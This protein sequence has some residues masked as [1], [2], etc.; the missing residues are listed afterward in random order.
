M[1]IQNFTDY[2]KTA[3]KVP[4]LTTEAVRAR[5]VHNCLNDGGARVKALSD[6]KN[7]TAED[8]EDLYRMSFGDGKFLENEH[9]NRSNVAEAV[10]YSLETLLFAY[11][12]MLDKGAA[13]YT[14][15]GSNRSY[16]GL[17]ITSRSES[18]RRAA[19]LAG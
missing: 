14:S 18:S 12:A 3:T 9:D 16:Y 11:K 15:I 13:A 5:L 4:E 7:P 17:S 10:Q 19:S 1:G 6:L 2:L 8:S